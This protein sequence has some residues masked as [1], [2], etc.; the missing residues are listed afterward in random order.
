MTLFEILI[1]FASCVIMILLALNFYVYYGF[2]KQPEIIRRGPKDKNRI[3]I[4]F[5]DGPEAKYTEKILDVLKEEK[6]KATFFVVGKQCFRYPQTVQRIVN[7]GHQIGNH[8]FGHANLV[9]KSSK[10]IDESLRKTNR[11]II[12]F[13]GEYPLVFRPPRG[14]YNQKVL[15]IA[16]RMGQKM[17][18]WTISS[19]DWRGAKPKHISKKISKKI[20]PGDIILFHDGGSVVYNKGKDRENTVEAL[21]PIIRM[22]KSKNL[23]LV[24]IDELLEDEEE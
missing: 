9:V 16:A 2:R 10:K 17:I 19:Q 6:V 15:R 8:T 23:K 20:K 18:L 22:I 4:T 12:Q 14:L 7:E 24:T 5:D 13:T 11:A 21:R 1:L 3:A